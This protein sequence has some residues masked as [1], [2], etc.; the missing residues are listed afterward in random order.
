MERNT[1]I[2]TVGLPRSGKSTWAKEQGLPIVSP[3]A[4]RLA[5]YNQYFI[6]EAEPMVWIMARYMVEALFLAGHCEVI[7]DATNTTIENRHKWKSKN[8]T[9]QYQV[10]DTSVEDC[11]RRATGRPDLLPIIKNM[12]LEPIGAQNE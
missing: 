10:F 11:K 1:L 5:L 4:I 2:M 8:W 12:L 3:D 9:R 7:L 6:T